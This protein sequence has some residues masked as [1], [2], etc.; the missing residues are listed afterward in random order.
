MRALILFLLIL[1]GM[2]SVTKHLPQLQNQQGYIHAQQCQDKRIQK[3]KVPPF[4]WVPYD[5][6]MKLPGKPQFT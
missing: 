4:L 2:F 3:V 6:W 1:P 5:E